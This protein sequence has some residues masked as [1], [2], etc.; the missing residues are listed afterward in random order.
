MAFIQQSGII[1]YMYNYYLEERIHL[2]VLIP[3]TIYI[4][5]D[6]LT[7]LVPGVFVGASVVVSSTKKIIFSA[8]IINRE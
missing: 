8:P 7:V 2:F 6:D 5:G 4:H 1:Y 3:F